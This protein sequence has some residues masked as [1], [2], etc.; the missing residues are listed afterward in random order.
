MAVARRLGDAGALLVLQGR[1]EQRLRALEQ[2]L[3]GTRW[4]AG[5]LTDPS[6]A[7]ELLRLAMA[8]HGRVDFAIN[9][10]GVN[11]T[12]R[13]ADVDLDKICS[14]ARIN[15]E[16]AYRFT[17]VFLRQFQAQ[18]G[19]H[20][21]HTT[22]VMG[23]KVRET[24]GAYAGTKH[25]IEALCEALRIELARS[26]IKVSCVAPGLVMTELHR[27]EPVHPSLM[28]GIARPLDPTDVADAIL[29]VISQPPHVNIP[30]LVI[31]PQDHPI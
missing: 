23:Y 6:Q 29:W 26:A 10:A 30:R 14:M 4:L 27:D 2:E 25:A 3:P 21:V 18:G 28:R 9:N 24:A 15:V 1:R 11:H 17:Y 8:N 31:L 12:G 7:T 5:D 16:A 19:G 13:I 22:S 20:L